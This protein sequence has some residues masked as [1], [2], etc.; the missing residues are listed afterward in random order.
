[1][2]GKRSLAMTAALEEEIDRK[3]RQ[4]IKRFVPSAARNAKFLL[5]RQETNLFTAAIVSAKKKALATAD[6]KE[7]IPVDQVLA[8]S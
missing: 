5:D 3:D 7:E 6:L 8:T 1:M 4:C 2:A